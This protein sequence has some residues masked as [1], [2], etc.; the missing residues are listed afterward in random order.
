[1]MAGSA[2]PEARNSAAYHAV[3]RSLAVACPGMP[4]AG[5]ATGTV[6]R[7]GRTEVAAAL[8][9]GTPPGRWSR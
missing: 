2:A 6:C 5:G 4:G 3:S 1:V 7:A 9:S 8:T